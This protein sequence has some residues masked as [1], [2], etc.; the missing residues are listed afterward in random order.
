MSSFGD[1]PDRGIVGVSTVRLGV[2]GDE[3]TDAQHNM[4]TFQR[5]SQKRDKSARTRANAASNAAYWG[6]QYQECLNK[7]AVAEAVSVQ[8]Q[9][10]QTAASVTPPGGSPALVSGGMDWTTLLTYGGLAIGGS[11]LLYALMRRKK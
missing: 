5:L 9:V 2:L 8:R 6:Q 4:E 11:L 10:S 7:K 1:V 3:C